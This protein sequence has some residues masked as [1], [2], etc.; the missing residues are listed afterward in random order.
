MTYPSHCLVNSLVLDL[1]HRKLWWQ[2]SDWADSIDPFH[3]FLHLRYLEVEE[4]IVEFLGCNETKNLFFFL[5]ST[6]IIELFHSLSHNVQE[7][8]VQM[9]LRE[10][11]QGFHLVW[12]NGLAVNAGYKAIVDVQLPL[13]SFVPETLLRRV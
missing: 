2:V 9:M 12:C 13:Y 4:E 5:F 8:L 6:F 7:G 3:V 10:V 11:T 1:S